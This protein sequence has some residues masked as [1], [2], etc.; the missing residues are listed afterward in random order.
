MVPLNIKTN[1]YLLHSMIK[2]KDL[3]QIA[4]K[5]NIKSLTITDDNMYGCIEFYKECRK[6]NIKPIIGIEISIPEKIILYAKNYNGYKNLMKI[7]TSKSEGSL[8]T[9]ILSDYSDDIVCIIPF[10]SKAKFNELKKIYRDL[11]VSYKNE[12]EKNRI[13]LDN[14]LY[15]NEILCIEKEDEKYLKYLKA[16]KE[17]KSY[18]EINDDFSNVS[19]LPL[20]SEDNSVIDELCNVEIKLHDNLLPIY[21]NDDS[22]Q[23]LKKYLVCKL[24]ENMRKD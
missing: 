23:L 15:M 22:Y 20:K 6:N 2:I 11:F 12:N 4:K 21:T 17:G 5:N 10:E 9:S 14:K 18:L 7:T 24:Q 1:Y 19:L 13:N 8:D 16:I 3:V